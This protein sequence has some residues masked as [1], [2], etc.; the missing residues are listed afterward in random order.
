M[1]NEDWRKMKRI[2]ISLLAIFVLTACADKKPPSIEGQWKLVSY[3][4]TGA[5]PDVETSIEFKDG[6]MSG[7]VGCNSFGGEYTVSGKTIKFGPV[8]S[9]MMFCDAVADQESSTLTV[10]QKD[11]TFIL[12]GDRLT[13]TSADGNAF[14]ILVRK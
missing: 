4:Q 2:L 9:T 6:Q 7:D 3:N 13:I 14:I 10:L 5:V 1:R 8:M 11:A 12:N